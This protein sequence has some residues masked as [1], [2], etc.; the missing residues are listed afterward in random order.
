MLRV[1]AGLSTEEHS[2]FAITRNLQQYGVGLS[3][4][5]DREAVAYTMETTSNNQECALGF[6]K[7]IIRPVFKPWEIDGVVPRIKTQ[8]ANMTPQV[9][10]LINIGLS[11]NI[12]LTI[13]LLQ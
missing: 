10:E 11:Y 1:C 5:S 9:R 7:D 8:L 13:N 3:V 2:A 4:S 12:L 6:L